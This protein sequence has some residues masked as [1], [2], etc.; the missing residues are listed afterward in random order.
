MYIL[1]LLCICFFVFVDDVFLFIY[2]LKIKAKAASFADLLSLGLLDALRQLLGQFGLREKKSR[3]P[4]R[5]QERMWEKI[6]ARSQSKTYNQQLRG[7]PKSLCS[8]GVPSNLPVVITER[9]KQKNQMGLG[10][11][12]TRVIV[13]NYSQ[14]FDWDSKT[15]TQNGTLIYGNK[16]YNL[17]NPSFLILS[18]PDYPSRFGLRRCGAYCSHR[19]PFW[20]NGQT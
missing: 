15:D 16:D 9:S 14:L 8:F 18:Q 3:I 10:T 5:G 2:F 7:I 19:C 4:S 17:H 12:N 13:V 6:N 1:L 11:E 20:E